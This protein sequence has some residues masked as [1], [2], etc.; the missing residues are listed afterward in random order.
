[1]RTAILISIFPACLSA[2]AFA[3]LT[4][5]KERKLF[6]VA[7]IALAGIL[8]FTG[9]H[10]INPN[11]TKERGVYT[12]VAMEGENLDMP[13]SG[14]ISYKTFARGQTPAAVVVGYGYW[15][16]GENHPQAFDLEV[17][18]IATGTVILTLSGEVFADKV[19]VTDLP[20]RK[21]GDYQL[22][23]IMNGSVYDTWDFTVNREV[24]AT[25]ATTTS[26]PPVYAKGDFSTSIEG[27]GIDAFDQ[28]VNAMLQALN[29]AVQEEYAKANQDDFA[30]VSPG[31]VVIQFDL[32][33]TG[34][35]SSSKIIENTLGSVLGQFFLRAL[36]DGSPYQPWPA[37][38]RAA[39]GA[40]TRSVKVTFYY[41]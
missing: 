20:I 18:E 11:V 33:E 21:S 10:S 22:K 4:V 31:H 19:A 27:L 30:Q 29:N 8:C 36:Q 16:N 23:L 1:M 26:Q 40:S 3:N 7:L 39:I 17:V 41:D 24:P 14:Y 34:Q 9:C 12:T 25:A 28:Y 2:T 13:G 5:M 15:D 38:A 37:A 6:P 32:S 35:V